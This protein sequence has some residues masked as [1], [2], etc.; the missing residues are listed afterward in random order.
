MQQ[1][2][3]HGRNWPVTIIFILGILMLMRLVLSSR[4]PSYLLPGMPHDDGWVFSRAIYMLKGE[5][6]GV[7]DQ[8]TLIKGAFP[9]V[10]LAFSATL[11]VAFSTLNTILYIF[12]CVVFVA[13]VRP[14]IKN[15]WVQ[16]L[17]FVVLL[18][19]PISYALHTGQRIYRIGMGQ[20]EI[21]LILGCFVAIFLRRNESWRGLLKWVLVGGV[22]LG[23]FLQTREDG[24]WIY[25][26]VLGAIGMTTAAFLLEKQ[27]SKKKVALFLLP[28]VIALLLNG[29]TAIV[30]Y[31]VYGA[32]VIND[33]SGG[34]YAKVAGDLN[35]I[36][37]NVDE[38]RLYKSEM[39]K[40]RYYTIYVSTM[41]KAFSVSPTLNSAAQPI[42]DA[43]RSWGGQEDPK[44]GQLSTDHMLFALRDG[45][46]L[47]GHY[48][49]LPETEAFYGKIHK[50]LQAAFDSGSLVKR[51]VLISPL[52]APFQKGD[53]EKTFS[54]LP[55]AIQE[56][57]EFKGIS[58]AAVPSLG[59]AWDIQEF[60]L[61]AGGDY[62][63]MPGWLVG[64]GWA[65][66]KSD[67]VRLNAGLYDKQGSL[68]T[69]LP[70]GPGDD[71]FRHMHSSKGIK[72]QNA[73]TPRF[74]FRVEGYD[75]KS[76]LTLRFFDKSGNIFRVIPVDG[77]SKCGED[78]MF[79]YCIDNLRS[80][81]SSEKFYASF[82][83][84]ANRIS[85]LYQ[86]MMPLISMLAVFVYLM[87]TVRLI[88]EVHRKQSLKTLSAWLALTAV[89]LTFLLFMF[90]MCILEATSFNSL[91]YWYTAPAY[92]LLLIFCAVSIG[93]GVESLLEFKRHNQ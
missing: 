83:D 8:L 66:A 27:G 50:E 30:N 53:L 45:V 84:R 62:F 34:N 51:G 31:A 19:N 5:W 32:P 16:I 25:P 85:N 64:S 55:R 26:Y 10:L 87:A 86:K 60:G 9:P 67:S 41:E 35:S 23:I 14:I 21:L 40:D 2:K 68:I 88:L 59:A 54:L 29:A 13:S 43:I 44:T 33:R 7:Y 52:V 81:S 70:F 48:Q 20:W 42:R 6:L 75:L 74:S 71:V 63:T 77:A 73:R 56:I 47:A 58:S 49:S 65:F 76:G 93:W 39:Y 11:G 1:Y 91:V 12:A 82:V 28:M 78:N 4:L 15:H 37:P 17:C 24:A 57:I 72:Y 22:T 90:G 3:Y 79:H 61:I 69:N 36:T 46:R 18:F 92:I 38:D 80:E 89:A